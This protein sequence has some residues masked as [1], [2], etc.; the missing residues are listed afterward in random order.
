LVAKFQKILYQYEFEDLINFI[1]YHPFNE[2]NP[3]H[4][5]AL[6]FMY[7]F[8]YDPHMGTR[9]FDDQFKQPAQRLSHQQS[10]FS[11]PFL[12]SSYQIKTWSGQRA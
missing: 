12:P 10:S 11:A 1:A 5:T 4:F 7:H 3:C 2:T 6:P 8:L 9:R